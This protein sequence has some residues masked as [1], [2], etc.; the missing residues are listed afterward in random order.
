VFDGIQNSVAWLTVREGLGICD[1]WWDM[2]WVFAA[3]QKSTKLE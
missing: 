1:T 3:F 2:W